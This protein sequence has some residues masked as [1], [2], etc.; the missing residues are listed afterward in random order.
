[1]AASPRLIVDCR[2]ALLENPLWA[3]ES[4]LVWFL[5]LLGPALH[6]YDPAT[7]AHER[8]VLGGT[9]PL[10]YL[11]RGPG[12]DG[13]L[14]ARRE[15]IFRLDP[16]SA[17]MSFWVDPN[18]GTLEV[19]C[20]DGKIGPDGALWL[21]TDDLAEK[22]PR[23][24]LWRVAPDGT[25]ALIDAGF[26]VGNG[27]AFSAD[28]RTMYLADTMG[29]RILAYELVPELGEVRSRRLFAQVPPE[30][31]YPDGMSVDAQG[32]LWVAHWGGS[33]ISRYDPDGDIERLVSMP[34]PNVTSL[35]FAGPELTTLYITTAREGMSPAQL[36]AAPEAGGL[37]RLETEIQG[38]LEPVM[39]G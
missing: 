25:A 15:G 14:L 10:G 29:G 34:V 7:G 28:G 39:P 37:Y 5:D 23:G 8:T 26:V 19:A 32:F 16:A 35:A 6:W 27:P 2:G 18:A 1:M 24:V 36:D 22:E 20:N 13:L 17:A 4:G 9:V 12:R 21:C 31:G 30:A 3:P 33:R 11:V 38:R